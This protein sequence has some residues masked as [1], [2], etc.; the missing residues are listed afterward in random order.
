[1]AI[2][3]YVTIDEK[4]LAMSLLAD[5]EQERR[6]KSEVLKRL[7]IELQAGEKTIDAYCRFL[8]QINEIEYTKP[9]PKE[10]SE[11]IQLNKDAMRM[12]FFLA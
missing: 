9:L 8:C 4:T 1:M 5:D 7:G 10:I 6:I 2:I 12:F 3:K 11:A